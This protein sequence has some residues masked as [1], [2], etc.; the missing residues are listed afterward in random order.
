MVVP[1]SLPLA[2]EHR[3]LVLFL[4]KLHYHNT[5]CSIAS[6]LLQALSTDTSNSRLKLFQ[7]V[8]HPPVISKSQ[9][10]RFPLA[11][12]FW[13]Q[14]STLS[15]SWLPDQP[16]LGPAFYSPSSETPLTRPVPTDLLVKRQ[17]SADSAADVL[18]V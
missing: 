13:A 3:D 7:Q 17:D 15:S 14:R 16:G 1:A 11:Q 2:S 18:H 6:P 8:L 4:L 12:N 5:L 9:E 10:S